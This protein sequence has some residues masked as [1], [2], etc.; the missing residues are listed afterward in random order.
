MNHLAPV[1]KTHC[2]SLASAG[3]A[4]HIKALPQVIPACS[5][6]TIRFGHFGH[7]VM[8]SAADVI[9]STSSAAGWVQAVLVAQHHSS[10]ILPLPNTEA[11]TDRKIYFARISH[12]RLDCVLSK[13]GDSCP[14]CISARQCSRM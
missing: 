3:D 10:R 7:Y 11:N 13:A 9:Q 12:T 2:R 8:A 5:Q 1:Y 4:I 6:Q 14:L